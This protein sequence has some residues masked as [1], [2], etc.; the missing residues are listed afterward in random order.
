M[1]IKIKPFFFLKNWAPFWHDDSSV[2]CQTKCHHDNVTT[3][4]DYSHTF[5]TQEIQMPKAVK[6]K[7]NVIKNIFVITDRENKNLNSDIQLYKET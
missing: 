1:I 7:K 6:K 4:S 3:Q 2:N 5:V